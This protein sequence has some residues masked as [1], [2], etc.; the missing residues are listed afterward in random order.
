MTAGWRWPNFSEDELK[1]Q[2]CGEFL[3]NDDHMDMLQL[4]RTKYG[5]PMYVT[6]GY[7]CENHSIEA[8][9]DEPGEHTTG[10]ATDVWIPSEDFMLVTKLWYEAGGRRCGWNPGVFIHLGSHPDFPQTVWV[11]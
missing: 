11:Y 2:H 9:K 10:R 8:A 6:S 3:L 7:R 4:V 1:C 5:K